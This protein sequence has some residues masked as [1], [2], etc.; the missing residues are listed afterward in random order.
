M[1]RITV[2]ALA[3]ALLVLTAGLSFRA[4]AQWQKGDGDP[5]RE[6]RDLPAFDKIDAGGSPKSDSARGQSNEPRW[7]PTRTFYPTLKRRLRMKR[8]SFPPKRSVIFPN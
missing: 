3:T 1:K 7:K 5:G 6:T 8:W 2:F 4:D